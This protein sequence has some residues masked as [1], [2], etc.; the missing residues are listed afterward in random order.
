MI[1]EMHLHRVIGSDQLYHILKRP[2]GTIVLVDPVD[3]PDAREHFR[4]GGVV[5]HHLGVVTFEEF[6]IQRLL[7]G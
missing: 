1:P 7:K 4:R 5:I 2:G 3:C 6:V